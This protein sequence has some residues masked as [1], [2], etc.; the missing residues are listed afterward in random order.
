MSNKTQNL[1]P[2]KVIKD[3]TANDQSRKRA[4]IGLMAIYVREMAVK[5]PENFKQILSKLKLELC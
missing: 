2:I 1:R 3:A 5:Y 4:E